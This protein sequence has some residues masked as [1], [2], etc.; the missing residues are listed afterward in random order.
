MFLV[1]TLGASPVLQEMLL[2][3]LRST[4]S[5]EQTLGTVINEQRIPFLKFTGQRNYHRK[6]KQH[7]KLELIKYIE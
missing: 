1:N 6:Q 7:C 3:K 4:G 5:E 2:N